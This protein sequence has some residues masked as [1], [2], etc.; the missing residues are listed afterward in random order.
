MKRVISEMHM[1]EV[2]ICYGMTETSPV[3]TQTRADD[4]L[5]RRVSTVGRVHPHLEVK[6]VDPETDQLVPIGE[7]GEFCTRG[8]SVMRG[9][10]N[11]P[12]KSAEVL[13]DGWMHTGDLATM[14][15]EGYL[16]IVGRIKD[17][18]I[19]GGE[20]V[21]PREIEE[22]L[23]TH[24][25]VVDAQVIGVPDERYGEELMAWVRLR[26]GSEPLTA[27]GLRGF[28]HGKLAHYKV[29]RYVH[30]V[31]DFP[32]TVTGKIRKVQMREE[33][34]EILGLHGAAGTHHA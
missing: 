13:R 3:S 25:D 12:E 1:D 16:N 10:W 14:D 33:A 8:Y 23:Y 5:D 29:P 17:M 24:P 28:C 26:E 31:E 32:M 6:V 30:V 11:E 21:Y 27:D 19:R 15:D 7:P 18:V 22:F 34:L 2:T 9:Y 20:N 4:S